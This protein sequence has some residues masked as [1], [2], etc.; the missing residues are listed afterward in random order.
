MHDS[1]VS[2]GRKNTLSQAIVSLEQCRDYL[3]GLLPRILFSGQAR[4]RVS[5]IGV[6]FLVTTLSNHHIE[7]LCLLAFFE[8]SIMT[9][10]PLL[11]IDSLRKCV[12]FFLARVLIVSPVWL[13]AVSFE[14]RSFG[15]LVSWRI[16][17]CLIS[18]CVGSATHWTF[19]TRFIVSLYVTGFWWRLL[20]PIIVDDVDRLGH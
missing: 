8:I 15:S 1:L 16:L 14:V 2:F 5:D 3:R 9:S 7:V 19:K 12:Y 17:S 10:L 6:T 18:L 20:V 11:L 13:E 4:S